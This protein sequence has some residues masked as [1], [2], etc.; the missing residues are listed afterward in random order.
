MNLPEYVKNCID[1]LEYSGYSAYAVGGA[2]R[3]S[4]LGLEP[5]DWDVTTSARPEEILSV[6]KDYRTIPT[7]IQHG[8]VTVLFEQGQKNIPIEITTFRID[9]EYRDSRHP[10][11]VEFSNRI[12]DD[13]SRRDFTVN[14]MAYSPKSGLVDEFGG[15]DDLDN[16]VIRAVGDPERRFSEDALRILR[17]FRFSAQLGFK[18][19]ENT[20]L[21][22]EKT[23]H[24]LN[25][26]ARERV[27]VELKKLLASEGVVY[28][29]KKMIEIGV[30]DE[31][32]YG[33][34]PDGDIVSRMS[35]LENGNFA[36]RLSV[37]ISDLSDEQKAE[38]LSS[39]RLSNDEKKLVLRLCRA[40]DFDFSNGEKSVLARKFLHLYGD[41]LDL[42]LEISEFWC[43]ENKRFCEC[44]RFESAKKN[45]LKV[46][47]LAIRGNDIL[48][49]VSNDYK[50]VGLI[51]DQLL[52]KVI[53]NPNLN[54]QE[55]L[56]EI[57]K[58]S[59]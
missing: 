23:A 1:K 43:K 15:K 48:P 8:T 35:E 39:I 10:E 51:L 30:W 52:E 5:S 33:F 41:I 31:L 50:K 56:I 21:A 34:V 57:I 38:I 25:N 20:L 27:G 7:G 46:S 16:R 59:I 3:D 58:K 22:A 44:V 36:T 18:I 24:L 29:L 13:L 2:V 28:S 6:F 37:L 14:A 11:S 40:K 4:L 42:S 55:K 49:Y 53:E 12:C 17:G 26:I 19:E 54:T 45:P 32:F 9:G 47:N